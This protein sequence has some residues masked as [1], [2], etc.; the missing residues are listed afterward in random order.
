MFDVLYIVFHREDF[1]SYYINTTL[2]STKKLKVDRYFSLPFHLLLIASLIFLH[3]ILSWLILYIYFSSFS[4]LFFPSYLYYHSFFFFL[5]FSP[6][7]PR[8]ISFTLII[9]SVCHHYYHYFPLEAL[10][11]W[12]PLSLFSLLSFFFSFLSLS[13][14]PQTLMNVLR[15]FII[16]FVGMLEWSFFW[17]D[18]DFSVGTKHR[19]L[20]QWVCSK[21]YF[22][23]C[24]PR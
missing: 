2:S 8:R 9:F 16:T 24:D 15:Y 5:F 17:C 10:S 22:F 21:K 13:Y 11:S 4:S 12:S 1:F 7:L 6:S 3:R 19:Y 14:H 18:P 20:P 23:R